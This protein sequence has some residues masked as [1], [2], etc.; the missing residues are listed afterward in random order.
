MKLWLLA[1]RPKTLT[2]AVVP[3]VVA[4]A[5]AYASDVIFEIWI[6]I[7][8]MLSAVFIQIATN[9]FNDAIDFHKGADTSE[10]IGPRRITASGDA[11]SA[12]VL[13]GAIYCLAMALGF[14]IPLVIHGGL[15]FVGIGLVS[16]F[17]AYG[18]T[19][20]PF[21]LAYLGLG[22]LFVLL[23]FGFIAVGGSYYLLSLTW[24]MD[25]LIAGFQIGALATVLIA[26]NNLRDSHQDILVGKKTM[27][28]R[29]GKTF[30]RY[31]IATLYT[32][33]FFLQLYWW[34][35]GFGVAAVLPL[36]F[37]PLA[38]A[39]TKSIFRNEPSAIYN[40]YLGL[41]ALVHMGFGFSFALG[42]FLS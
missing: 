1:F 16:M 8:A 33:T 4:S 18:Y 12:V 26:I 34:Q 39:V 25:C 24:S 23:F 31:E 29:L 30:V 38:Y 5:L 40:K 27:A 22:D 11:H 15:L 28:V 42:L 20:G 32:V 36:L 19:G 3:V 35:R 9:L 6:P 37:W 21:P 7:C 10:R 13:R 41:S 17:L 14:G 2:A